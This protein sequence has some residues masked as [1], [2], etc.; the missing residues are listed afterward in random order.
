[1][2]SD[3]VGKSFGELQAVFFAAFFEVLIEGEVIFVELLDLARLDIGDD[4]V[5]IFNAN[6]DQL[7]DRIVD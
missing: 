3:V 7:L 2:N 4:H 5:D 1:M 6:F